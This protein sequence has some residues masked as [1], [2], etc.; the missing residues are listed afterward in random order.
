MVVDF[1]L[2]RHQISA[3]C[4]SY[5]LALQCFINYM[6]IVFREGR[7]LLDEMCTFFSLVWVAAVSNKK[8]TSFFSVTAELLLF[9]TFVT[10]SY[11]S[12]FSFFV[13]VAGLYRNHSYV[14]SFALILFFF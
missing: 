12:L 13:L 7:N 14:A 9:I 5:P 10:P 3:Y 2:I 6:Y 11:F 1:S 8:N 4:A